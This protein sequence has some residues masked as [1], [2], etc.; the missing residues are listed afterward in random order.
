[1]TIIVSDDVRS[2]V[3]NGSEYPLGLPFSF[4]DKCIK[5]NCECH[6]DG[7]LE[8]PADKAEDTCEYDRDRQ[9][10]PD[11]DYTRTETLGICNAFGKEYPRGRPFSF[12]SGCIKYNCEC[13]YNGSWECPVDRSENTC[14]PGRDRQPTPDR[15]HM[16]I[17][18]TT[19]ERSECFWHKNRIYSKILWH[20]SD[21]LFK[22]ISLL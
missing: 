15:G 17:E 16:G 2:C 18:T 3:I 20:Y 14:Q 13:H 7:S 9:P 5:Y 21:S 12:M 4:M 1:M 8:C 11:R 22:L 6:S 19:R 10:I